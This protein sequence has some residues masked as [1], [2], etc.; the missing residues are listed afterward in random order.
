MCLV[1]KTY[2]L[3]NYDNI[4]TSVNLEAQELSFSRFAKTIEDSFPRGEMLLVQVNI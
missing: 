2:L 1:I 3:K 4:F